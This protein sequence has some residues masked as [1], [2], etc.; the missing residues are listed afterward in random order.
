M[1]IMILKGELMATVRWEYFISIERNDLIQLGRE[2]WE[3]INVAIVRETETFYFKRPFPSIREEIT[4]SQ[5]DATL[6]QK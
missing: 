3:L 1:P 4:L 5:R 6:K 2:G